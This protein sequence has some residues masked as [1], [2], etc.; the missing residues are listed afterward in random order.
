MIKKIYLIILFLLIPN[1]SYAYLDPGMLSYVVA[2][3]ATFFATLI[4]F[5][6]IFI[7]KLKTLLNKTLILFKKKEK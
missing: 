7:K 2:M 6:S 1:I 5:Y 3:I 4:T